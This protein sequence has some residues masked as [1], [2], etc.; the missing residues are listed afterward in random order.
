M[1]ARG[2]A[3][4]QNQE[5]DI[6]TIRNNIE[7]TVVKRQSDVLA[8]VEGWRWTCF[9]QIERHHRPFPGPVF[10]SMWGGFSNS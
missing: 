4:K 2:N 1:N 7:K 5:K 10:L 9:Q 6:I 3:T 8:N